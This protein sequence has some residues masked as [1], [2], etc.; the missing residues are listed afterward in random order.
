MY[1]RSSLII[2]FFLAPT[3]ISGCTVKEKLIKKEE[4]I[5]EKE[6]A[7]VYL[8]DIKPV[9]E[10]GQLVEDINVENHRLSIGNR[11]YKKGL[12]V[13]SNLKVTYGLGKQFEELKAVIGF[14]SDYPEY[15]GKV[16]FIVYLDEDKAYES[17]W[18]SY[19][20]TENISIS[21]KDIDKLTLITQDNGSSTDYVVWADAKLLK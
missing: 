2:L 5:K 3:I 15:K 13:D 7:Y 21:L 18:L 6:P 14:H 4:V 20:E 16:K 9:Q 19:S 11:T 8:S 10:K 17:K 1:R 12:C